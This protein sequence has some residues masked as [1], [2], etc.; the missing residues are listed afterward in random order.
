MKST[1]KKKKE[2]VNEQFL[3]M[4][5]LVGLI[6]ETQ[7]KQ[8]MQMLNESEDEEDELTLAYTNSPKMLPWDV[9]EKAYQ[10]SG[11]SGE[12]FFSGHEVEFINQFGGK[13]IS[14][15]AYFNFYANMPEF[16]GQDDKYTMVNW[17]GF[18]DPELADELYS[19]I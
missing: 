9:I 17:I 10:E 11:L 4:Q 5:K 2:S 12:E 8:K 19:K 18:S 14:K 6:T 16:G 13:P 1:E 15:E 3:H 7:Y